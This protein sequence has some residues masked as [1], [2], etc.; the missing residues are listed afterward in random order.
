MQA[1]HSRPRQRLFQ[2]AGFLASIFGSAS[3]E[4]TIPDTK[5]N[6]FCERLIGSARRE[7]LDFMI[8]LNENHARSI[9]KPW[10]IHFNRGRPHSSLGPGL[11]EPS[12][13]K[14]PLQA[15]RHRIPD[16]HRVSAIP[17]L[18][19]LHHEFHSPRWLSPRPA[20]PKIDGPFAR[21][22]RPVVRRLEDRSDS[23]FSAL[24]LSFD[25]KLTPSEED[26][27]KRREFVASALRVAGGLVPALAQTAK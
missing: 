20:E 18:G 14:V 19:G 16:S 2:R 25:V 6:I 3:I 26:P 27:M 7:C 12:V 22:Y 1:R 23:D 9:L 8:P 10:T 13:P 4:D 17:M 11:P 5:A 24:L 21:R 15:E